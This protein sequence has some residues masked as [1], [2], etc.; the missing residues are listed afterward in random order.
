MIDPRWVFLSFAL[1]MV[2]ASRYAYLT[3]RGRV[4][5]NLVSWSL[6]AAAPLIGFLAQLDA[7]VGLPAV[8]TLAAGAGPALVC[9]AGIASRHGRTRL[10]V[11]DVCCGAVAAVALVVWLGRGQAPLAVFVAIAA[12]AI[13]AIPTLRKAWLDPHSENAT[14]YALAG[15]GAGITLLTIS[16]WE[17]ATWAFAA[18]VLLLTAVL[19]AVVTGRRITARG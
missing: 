10:T 3:L 15:I 8:Q 1:S 12:D 2:G 19:T 16:S 9:V 14:T 7:G 17:P 6:W 4:R 18:Y 11:F 5:P 13:A